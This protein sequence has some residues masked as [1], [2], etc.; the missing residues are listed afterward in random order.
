MLD[1]LDAIKV[2]VDGHGKSLVSANPAI[3]F[4][5]LATVDGRSISFVTPL[6]D[7]IGVHISA[8]TSSM[9][10]LCESFSKEALRSRSQ[11]SLTSS[12]HGVIVVVR[13]PCKTKAFVVS[14]ATDSSESAAMALRL[15]LD[16]ATAVGKL[17]DASAKTV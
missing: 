6:G 9:L 13:V 10:A 15:A 5:C 12:E 14:L 17:I 3:T 16:S 1:K 7:L 8:I 2:Q 4:F 11:Y